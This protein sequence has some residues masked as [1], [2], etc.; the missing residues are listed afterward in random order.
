MSYPRSNT[1][2]EDDEML[3]SLRVF[4][5]LTIERGPTMREFLEA[6]N[7]SSSSVAAYRMM[8]LE[9]AGW[10]ERIPA[11]R[12]GSPFRGYRL[13]T[14]GREAAEAR[15]EQVKEVTRG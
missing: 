1:G 5:E 4:A 12:T 15:S 9:R 7:L 2:Y 14:A 6:L 10:I 13:T 8:L 11:Q 3:P